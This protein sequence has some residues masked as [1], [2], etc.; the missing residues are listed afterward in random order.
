MVAAAR[1]RRGASF[2]IVQMI[3]ERCFEVCLS[4][5][6]YIEWVSVLTRR[7]NLPPDITS[8]KALGFLRHL[9]SLSH[10]QDIHYLVAPEKQLIP[11]MVNALGMILAV[12]GCR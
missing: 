12:L 7:E 6:L 4:V 3:P 10:L 5:G 9:A 11:F 8:Q 1:S 2:A